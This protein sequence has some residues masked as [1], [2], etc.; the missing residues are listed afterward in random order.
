MPDWLREAAVFETPVTPSTMAARLVLAAAMGGLVAVVYRLSHGQLSRDARMMVG[1]LVL[2]TILL[3][4]VTMVIGESVARAFGLVGALSI[5]RFRTVVED[6][7]DTA[8]VVFAVV[9]GMAVG[10]GL[11]MVAVIGVPVVGAAALG[12]SRWGR[13]GGPHAMSG[14]PCTLTVRMGTGR[15][16]T[17]LADFLSRRSSGHRLVSAVTARQGAAMDLVYEVQLAPEGD[18]AALVMELSSVDG[19]QSAELRRGAAG[20]DDD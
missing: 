15:A 5:V 17:A 6:T 1:T 19:V 3:A 9:V 18:A 16:P 11:L 2:L 13:A 4:M 10:T 7:R 14:G 8:F 12:L 20:V